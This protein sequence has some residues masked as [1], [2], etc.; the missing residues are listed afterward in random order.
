L[1]LVDFDKQVVAAQE[2]LKDIQCDV[3]FEEESED[4]IK[5]KEEQDLEFALLKDLHKDDRRTAMV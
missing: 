3:D 2:S 4:D 1:K 5:E